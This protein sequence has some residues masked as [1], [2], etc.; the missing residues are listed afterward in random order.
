MIMREILP[1]A[2]W[3]TTDGTIFHENDRKEAQKHQVRLDFLEW[4]EDSHQAS[5][6]S[7]EDFLKWLDCH[8]YGL[9]AFMKEYYIS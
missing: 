4:Y 5:D 8:W 1:V 7:G 2:A 6:L 9:H 3:E